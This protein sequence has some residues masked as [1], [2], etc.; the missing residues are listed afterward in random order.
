MAGRDLEARQRVDADR[1]DDVVGQRDE[2]GH[3]H[4]PLAEVGPDEQ[5][6]QH[7]EDAESEQGALGDLLAPA[8]RRSPTVRGRRSERAGRVEDDLT[9]SALSSS[10]SGSVWTRIASLPEVVTTGEEASSMPVPATASRRSSAVSWLTCP[11]EQGDAVLRAAG[12]LDAVVEA[13][14]DEPAHGDQHDHAGDGVPEPSPA[15]EVDRTS[16]RSRGR[17]RAGRTCP[18]GPRLP[19]GVGRCRGS[20][21]RGRTACGPC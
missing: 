1:D 9:T 16:C 5:H 6:H 3:R 12:E 7:Q 13:L 11:A 2:R 4:L 14:D 20:R 21:R 15:D 10:V 8:R 17:C 19:S 18:S